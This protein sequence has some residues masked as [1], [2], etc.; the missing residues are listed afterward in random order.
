MLRKLVDISEQTV[1]KRRP[2]TSSALSVA[3]GLTATDP[4]WAAF[5]GAL[6]IKATRPKQF[7]PGLKLS[8]F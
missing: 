3:S 1:T 2:Y 5:G 8:S 6:D 7:I 4:T